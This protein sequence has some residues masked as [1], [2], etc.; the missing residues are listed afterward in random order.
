MK[1]ENPFQDFL[2]DPTPYN[3]NAMVKAARYIIAKAAKNGEVEVV[4]AKSIDQTK[5]LKDVMQY[6]KD[7][8]QTPEDLEKAIE[9]MVSGFERMVLMQIQDDQK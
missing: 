4:V 8:R 5:N 9:L 6:V 7:N 1:P 3:I 2:K